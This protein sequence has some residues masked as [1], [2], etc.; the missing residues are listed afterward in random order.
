MAST[1][2][3]LQKDAFPGGT[4]DGSGSPFRS[5]SSK[6]GREQQSTEDEGERDNKRRKELK[7][8]GDWCREKG[9]RFFE[10]FGGAQWFRDGAMDI[11]T[12]QVDDCR[13]S[14]ASQDQRR[15]RSM[16]SAPYH[17]H[18]DHQRRHSNAPR[19]DDDDDHRH[20]H[21]HGRQRSH[22]SQTGGTARPR[23]RER[24]NDNDHRLA[25]RLDDKDVRTE[26][27]ERAVTAQ[28]RELASLRHELREQ[29]QQQEREI[30]SL[31]GQL[32]EVLQQQQ[33][34]HQRDEIADLRRQLERQQRE[35]AQDL[36]NLQDGVQSFLPFLMERRRQQQQENEEEG[37]NTGSGGEGRESP[38]VID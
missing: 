5:N 12:R 11:S 13:P 14:A 33:N 2:P 22:G 30:A 15:R 20:R 31:R 23:S 24:D 9:F 35:H 34:Q 27:L 21:H 16:E 18:R 7:H 6:R 29:R 19:S 37:E 32:R 38:I 28:A 8:P 10:E 25:A 4:S 3:H 17:H 36:A 26:K 1:S